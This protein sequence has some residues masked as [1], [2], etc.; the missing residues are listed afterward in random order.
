MKTEDEWAARR[1]RLCLKAGVTNL[2]AGTCSPT[3]RMALDALVGWQ[4]VKAED[5]VQFVF[6]TAP[7]LV[8]AAR[9]ELAAHLGVD[10]RSLLLFNNSTYA[11]N[12]VAR[13]IAWRPGDEVVTS[14]Q[15]YHHY[16]VMWRRLAAE[17]GLVVRTVALP[18]RETAP[19]YTPAMLVEAFRAQTGP[20]TRAVFFSHVTSATGLRFPALELCKLARDVGALSIVDGAHAPGLVPLPLGAMAPDFYFANVHKWMMGATG[21]AFLF[22]RP[23]LRSVTVPL[24]TTA[25]FELMRDPAMLDEES[26][27]GTTR[28][29]HAHEYQGTRDLVPLCVLP[30]VLR[31][32]REV[33]PAEVEERTRTLAHY[34]RN[35]LGS[36]M[37]VVSHEHPELSTCMVAFKVP[38]AVR[39][40]ADKAWNHFRAVEQFEV[41]MPKLG[42]GTQLLRV[43]NAWFNTRGDVDALAATL[44]RVEWGRFA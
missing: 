32:L 25:T 23:E 26:E 1:G 35:R 31:F 19:G 17:T 38:G 29:C 36:K 5:P 2:N 21:S 43:S 12:T 8:E 37:T 6:R 11:M 41:A 22:V 4:T 16:V 24:V 20:K 39:I 13:S 3:S 18:T 28:W 44:E 7:L 10:R 40:D 33:T 34:C 9:R 14:D 30:E 15:E 27:S 42:D